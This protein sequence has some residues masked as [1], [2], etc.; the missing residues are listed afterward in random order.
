MLLG[1]LLLWLAGSGAWAL[2]YTGETALLDAAPADPSRRHATAVTFGELGVFDFRGDGRARVALELGAFSSEKDSAKDAGGGAGRVRARQLGVALGVNETRPV[3]DTDPVELDHVY[4]IF[5]RSRAVNNFVARLYG[6]RG[7]SDDAAAAMLCSDVGSWLESEFVAPISSLRRPP[8]KTKDAAKEDGGDGQGSGAPPPPPTTA[9]TEKPKISF[10]AASTP[11]AGPDLLPR[12]TRVT[13]LQRRGEQQAAFAGSEATESAAGEEGP[14]SGTSDEAAS[15]TGVADRPLL[16]NET[17]TNDVFLVEY[18]WE[19]LVPRGGEYAVVIAN[20]AA[21]TIQFKY[22][23]IMANRWRD[24]RWTNLPAGWMPMQQV[25][26]AVCYSLWGAAVAAWAA[27][28]ARRG[29]ARP[30]VGVALGAVPV[31]RF[32]S[33]LADR[34]R[35]RLWGAGSY[36]VTMVVVST[37]LVDALADGAQLLA[38]LTLAKGW[39]VVR[40]RLAGAE[41]RLV[42]GLVGFVAIATLYDGATRGGGVLAVG[43]LQATAVAYAWASLAHTRR[44]HAVQTLR[45]VSRNEAAL[46]GW[47]AASGGSGSGGSGGSG[48]GSGPDPGPDPGRGPPSASVSAALRCLAHR[49][50]RDVEAQCGAQRRCAMALVWSAVRKDRLLRVLLRAALPLQA[51][52]VAALVVGAFAVPPHHAY[53]ALLVAQAAHWVAFMALF[54]AVTCGGSELP[55]VALPPLPAIAA[56][57]SMPLPPPNA[58]ATAPRPMPPLGRLRLLRSATPFAVR[59]GGPA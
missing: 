15:A 49:R 18:E 48:S 14:A 42:P 23:L 34:S 50:W 38:V 46:V 54:A 30:T 8:A 44:V 58:A 53:A 43:V 11:S 41:K 33:C 4:L 5:A 28:L 16:S 27:C 20:C 55:V 31:L 26:P 25:Y 47:W 13:G 29:A 19:W 12:P 9:G 24:G 2:N 56:R 7:R 39:G 40:A 10:I 3:R 17:K 37:S 22:N 21:T 45:L 36:E 32:L 6:S 51:L 35:Y 57:R 52:D 1:A 59:T